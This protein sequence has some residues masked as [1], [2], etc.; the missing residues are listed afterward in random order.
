[1]ITLAFL[2]CSGT[3]GAATRAIQMP[4]AATASFTSRPPD[5]GV[6]FELSAAGDVNGDGI[7]DM[8]I[9][10]PNSG[11]NHRGGS[12]SVYVVFGASPLEPHVSLAS[13]GRRGFRI[14]GAPPHPGAGTKLSDGAG[15]ALAP[16]GDVT[17]DGL[18]DVAVGAS[19]ASPRKRRGAGAVYI[20]Y[21]K[22]TTERVDLK[23][24]GEGGYRIDGARA[25]ALTGEALAPAGDVNGDGLGDLLV[26]TWPH[27]LGG[28]GG[29]YVVFGRARSAGL[30][31]AHLGAEGIEF[32]RGKLETGPWLDGLGDVNGD[33]LADI[34]IGAPRRHGTGKA[35]VVYGRTA[36][37]KVAL[38]SLPSSA[39]Y[40]ISGGEE[41]GAQVS[42]PGDVN[43]DGRVDVL[44]GGGAQAV[45]VLFNDGSGNP[46]DLRKPS[47]K[48]REL[49]ITHGDFLATAAGS[50]DANGDGLADL[51]LADFFATPRCHEGA[52][53][54]AVVYGRRKA[55][56]VSIANLAGGG[57]RIDG[58]SPNEE[59]GSGVAWLPDR[60]GDGGTDLLVGAANLGRSGAAYLVSGRRTSAAVPARAPCFRVRASSQR[61]RVI[62]RTGRLRV[63]VTWR[64][65]G[66]VEVGARMKGHGLVADGQADFGRPGTRRVTLRLS[67]GARRLFA[68]RRRI[69]LT[70]V[71]GSTQS[72]RTLAHVPVVFR[73]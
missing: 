14:D 11:H 72:G 66:V 73:R 20:V 64:S 33:E 5:F 70:I 6:G 50:G 15:S 1:V 41:I 16:L 60:D 25:D 59:L 9:A 38:G 34:V 65:F 47:T 63:V 30:D 17:G 22:K 27:L 51:L 19:E 24:L 56:S 71:I 49:V 28:T 23:D 55:S 54:A 37:G 57:Y 44:V 53:Y 42:G 36:P 26:G 58:G 8:L 12:G 7:G 32:P 67:P 3:A 18:A 69:R 31:L 68:S 46:V 48:A 10:D 35:F 40:A 21:G 61:L 62:A 2:G 45:H 4:G 52:G 39:G 29:L 43:G 13:L